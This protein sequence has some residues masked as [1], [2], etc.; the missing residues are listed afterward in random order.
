VNFAPDKPARHRRLLV[1]VF[2]RADV[3]VAKTSDSALPF[4]HF[5]AAPVFSPFEKGSKQSNNQ[6]NQP[7]FNA[8]GLL[9]RRKI[10]LIQANQ[11]LPRTASIA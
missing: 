1:T 3:L 5:I 8:A 9:E 11:T 2:V 6:T 10:A 4:G 7:V